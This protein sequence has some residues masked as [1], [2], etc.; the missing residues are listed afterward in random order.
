MGRW[1]SRRPPSRGC[2]APVAAA[3]RSA[4]ATVRSAAAAAT[5]RNAA[6]TPIPATLRAE[7]RPVD[8]VQTHVAGFTSRSSV[9]SSSSA[10]T[11][12]AQASAITPSTPSASGAPYWT[13]FTSSKP[14]SWITR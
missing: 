6:R 8:R 13:V 14:G 1:R 4:A 3:G 5:P 9:A 7:A 11:D 10:R 2:A 12:I